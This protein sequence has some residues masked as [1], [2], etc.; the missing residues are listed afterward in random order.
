MSLPNKFFEYLAYGLPIISSL[1]SEMEVLI[2]QRKLGYNYYSQSSESLASAIIKLDNN[3]KS[4]SSK[5]LILKEFEDNFNGDKIYFKFAE[6]VKKT[7]NT[8]S[9]S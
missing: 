9:K 6:F 4:K 3:F 5:N 2:H 8:H 7:F 1:K